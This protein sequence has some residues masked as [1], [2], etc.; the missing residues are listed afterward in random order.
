MN[1]WIFVVT[2]HKLDNGILAPDD[3]LKQRI[4]DKYWGLGERTPNRRNLKKGDKVVFYLGNPRKVF[5]VIATLASDSFQ[6]TKEQQTKYEHGYEF[7]HSE[8]GVFLENIEVLAT[9]RTAEEV[10]PQLKFIENKVNWGAYFQGGVRQASEEDFRT[11]VEGVLSFPTPVVGIDIESKSEFALEIHLE[12]FIYH[13]WDQIDFGSKLQL[14]QVDEQ[15]GRQ[16][17]AG[18]WS[19]DFLCIDKTDKDFVVIELKRGKS[20]DS[21]VG[22]VLRYIG[23]V[24]ENFAAKNQKVRGII[25]A[26]EIDDAMRYAI[27]DLPHITALTY[28]VDF[29]LSKFTK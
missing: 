3:I 9:P 4:E 8:Y 7:Y 26:K 20:S 10:I 18:E 17:P 24:K 16:F 28:R 1:Y 22:Q 13:N 6:L 29:A 11:I 14:Y 5:S 12:E 15:D 27:N 21:T 23:W 19:I 2:Q 25:I